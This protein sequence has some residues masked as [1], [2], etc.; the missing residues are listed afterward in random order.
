MS[1]KTNYTIDDIAR[2]L[3]VSK[4]T[5]SRALSGKGR[6]SE[7]TTK[8]VKDFVEK[9]D[10]TPNVMARGLAQ[11]KTYNIAL[12]LPSDF[13]ESEIAFFKEVTSGICKVAAQNNY[14]VMISLLDNQIERMITNHKVDGIILT[15]SVFGSEIPTYLNTKKVPFI[16]VGSGDDENVVYIDN[17][18]KTGSRVLT[19]YLVTEC[20]YKKLY[21]I[22]G[23]EAHEVSMSRR[24][25]F[26][27]AF[28][29]A[30]DSVNEPKVLM[31]VDS[32]V[33]ASNAV[34]KA[35]R[36]KADC[37]V[38]MD[39][40]VCNLVLEALHDKGIKVPEDVAVAS[41]YDSSRLQHNNPSITSL[42][43]STKALGRKACVTMLDMLGEQ[44]DPE[45]EEL[46]FRIEAR[47][48]T[49]N[50]EE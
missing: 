33:K 20:G 44:V 1:E 11:S 13:G 21:L 14:D 31:G 47:E 32:F 6:I 37:I 23:N 39:D 34:D 35:L 8:M 12:Q 36:H 29:K 3:G 17:D 4:T 25:G 43:Y 9:H 27:M 48:S 7:K 19:E 50:G 2:E 18:N 38:C 40:F 30:D 46:K 26:E 5:V 49:R 15:R 42:H 28:D 41:L 16:M 10:F 22:G 24:R 45:T